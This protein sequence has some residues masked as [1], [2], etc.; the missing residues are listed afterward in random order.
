MAVKGSGTVAQSNNPDPPM[1][2]Q[3]KYDARSGAGKR[4]QTTY[5]TKWGMVDQNPEKGV[6]AGLD[7]QTGVW[8]KPP[9]ASSPNVM[10]PEPKAKVLRR[11]AQILQTPHG[12]K[13]ASSGMS[14]SQRDGNTL[15]G[16]VG[17]KVLGEAILS[18]STKLPGTNVE[19]T[20]S[21]AA[22]KPWPVSDPN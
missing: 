18:G 13:G 22:P 2:D 15:T 6:T 7:P 8:S 5:P 21:G 10:D 20:D 16:N 1:A 11:Q 17:G 14:P 12:M 19:K 9:D 3:T 4:T